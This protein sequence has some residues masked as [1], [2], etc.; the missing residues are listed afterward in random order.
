MSDD[1]LKKIRLAFMQEILP[2]GMALLG[3][4]QEG[5]PKKVLE[6]F[7]S[8]ESPLE[9]LRQ[10]GEESAKTFRGN[11]DKVSPGL[12]NPVMQVEVSVEESV[13]LEADPE[14]C[15]D[16]IEHLEIIESRLE[17]LD[18]YLLNKSTQQDS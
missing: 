17:Q 12:G 8:T 2:V 10:E 7:T 13:D 1:P 15:D 18:D 9:E 3:R 14:D 4:A 6:V 11:L 16:L 5:G